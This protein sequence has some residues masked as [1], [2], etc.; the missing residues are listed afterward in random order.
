MNLVSLLSHSEPFSSERARQLALEQRAQQYRRTDQMFARLLA[1]EFVAGIATALW[2]SPFA[3]SGHESQLHPHVWS[4]MV[5]GALIVSLPI[6]LA[7]AHPGKSLTRQVIGIAQLLMSGLLIHLTQGRI[8]THFHVF[9]SLAFLAFYRDWRVLITATTVTAVDHLVRGYV[10]PLS[11]YGT[12]VQSPWR[13][14]E[15]SAWVTFL[16]ILASSSTMASTAW[17]MPRWIW[18]GLAPLA[19]FFIPS[20]KMASA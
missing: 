13:W 3:W 11:I 8:E 2:I 16:D 17:L 9:G 4:A 19:T 6:W 7:R 15:H 10:W 1:F 20:A 14:I 5:L 18:L 12:L